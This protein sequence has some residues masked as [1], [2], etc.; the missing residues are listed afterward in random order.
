MKG[1]QQSC[2]SKAFIENKVLLNSFYDTHQ[3]LVLL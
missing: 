3:K 2:E 1:V